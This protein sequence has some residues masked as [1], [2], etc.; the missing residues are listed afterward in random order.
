MFLH[1]LKTGKLIQFKH[2][3]LVE[4]DSKI[5]GKYMATFCQLFNLSSVS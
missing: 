1:L 5:V 2:K 4:G 3:E